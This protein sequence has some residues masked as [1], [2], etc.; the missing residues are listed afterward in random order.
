MCYAIP[1]KVL[2]ITGKTA[3]VNYYGEKKK[4]YTDLVDVALGDYVYAQ[5]GFIITK[6]P[7]AEALDILKDWQEL[8]FKLQETD[9]KL[10]NNPKTIYE[11]ANATRQKYQGNSCCVHGILEF[12]NY[13][14]NDCLYCGIRKSNPNVKRYRMSVK[15]ILASVEYAVNKLGFKALV[16]QSGE[17]PWYDDEELYTIVKQIREKFPVLIFLS[18]GERSVDLYKRLYDLGARGALIRFETCNEKLYARI[19]PGSTLKERLGLI[20]ELKKIG[21]LII[22]GFLVGLPGQKSKDILEG[23][24]LTAE[25]GA[26]QP[27]G[28]TGMFSFGPFIPHPETPL[29][30]SPKPKLSMM[31]NT[32]AKAR[33]MN[34]DAK[35]LVTTALETLDKKKGAREGLMAGANSLMVNITPIKYRR[36]YEIYPNRAGTEDEVT[37]RIDSVLK[38][39]KSLG[40]APTD[41]GV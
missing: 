34:P 5:G 20:R 25:L 18:I 10:S 23:I 24:K 27:T 16:I 11:R 19:K 26:D 30:D 7:E 32:I 35:I 41:L 12:S 37:E 9:K 39:L 2:E 40:R 1:G 31:L 29:A 22:T 15:E 3:T 21:Y 17:D 33:L 13:C 28:E 36:M 6:V 38:L 8:F 14:K 4:A